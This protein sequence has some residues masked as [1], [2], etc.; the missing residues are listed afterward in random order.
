MAFIIYQLLPAASP[1]NMINIAVIIFLQI[2]WFSNF[3]TI[4]KIDSVHQE[5]TLTTSQTL[6]FLR[7]AAARDFARGRCCTFT[8]TAAIDTAESS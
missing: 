6:D 7:L 4:F 2:T 8:L 1:L 5:L 3:K